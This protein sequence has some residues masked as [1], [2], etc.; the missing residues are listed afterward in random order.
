MSAFEEDDVEVAF[1][2]Q[3]LHAS[4]LEGGV[5]AISRA[6]NFAALVDTL[7]DEFENTVLISAGDNYIP[8]PFFNAASD[9]SLA[10]PL[11]QSLQV[12]F[13][14]AAL[15]NIRTASG[16]YDI[17][18]MNILGFDASAV[19]NHE[20]DAGPDAFETVIEDDVRD[21]GADL[22][23]L[24][25]QFPYV[26]ANLD[27][28][29][30]PD[31]GNL[32]TSEILDRE[33]FRYE[34]TEARTDAFQP[35]L[36]PATIID[37]GGEKIGVVGATTQVLESITSVGGVTV[38]RDDENSIGNDMADLAA[39]LQPTID[40]LRDQGVNKIILTSHLQQIALEEEL[41]QLLSGVDIII[42][43]GSDTLLADSTDVLRSGDVAERGYPIVTN[44]AD[45]DP[46]LIVSTDGEYS[47]LGR[48]VVDFDADGKIIVDNLDETVSGA[49]A[50]T[51]DVVTDVTG[52]NSAIAA[53]SASQKASE[54]GDLVEAVEGI[55]TGQDGNVFG[56]TQ[57]FIEG[58]REQ[59]RTEETTLGNLTADANL[60]YA[61]VVDPTV[62]IA[63]KNGGGIRAAIGEVDANSTLLPTQGNE[64]AGK[65]PGEISQL[66]IANALRFNNGLTLLTLTHEELAIVLEHAV[67][68]TA[69][70]VTPGQFAQVAGVKFSYDPSGVAQQLGDDGAVLTAG[71]R[72]VNA[73]IVDEAGDVVTT[74]IENGVVQDPASEVRIV[75]LDFLAGGGDGYPYDAFAAANPGRVNVVNLEALTPD[76][77]NPLNDAADFAAFGSE[78]D[79]LAEFL[80]DNFATDDDPAASS[81]FDIAETAPEDDRRIQDTSLVDQT[82]FFTNQFA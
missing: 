61:Q 23:W 71:S 38:I 73:A 63:L 51:D 82:E 72:I 52:F 64:A 29:G 7:E 80:V 62:Q 67:A 22:R 5:D 44:D 49:F 45:G 13:D 43:G 41:A 3:L 2:L 33:E 8:G 40:A 37:E 15:T 39:V 60:A 4:D 19:G 76:A 55:V 53:R 20:F 18:I 50:T 56:E 24:G 70:G 6:P 25:T 68:A 16:R 28:S 1:T 69:P 47:Y 30:S 81:G 35:R 26:A 48:L 77:S 79:A 58:R 10:D 57:V 32:F 12:L 34:P 11:E 59:V 74:L 14:D 65:D 17:A 31:L 9:F 42:A 36:A 27:F 78:Q 66:D 21:G 46:T 75:T 54:V